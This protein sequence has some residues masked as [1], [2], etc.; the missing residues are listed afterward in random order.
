MRMCDESA[1]F[2]EMER[3]LCWLDA[4]GEEGEF[5]LRCAIGFLVFSSWVGVERSEN[6]RDGERG[7]RREI[8]GEICNVGR[9]H[10]VYLLQ[11]VCGMCVWVGNGGDFR[12]EDV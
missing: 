9:N 6:K 10:S 2:I 4:W 12:V 11:R 5:K 1:S 8:D 7:E 3:K